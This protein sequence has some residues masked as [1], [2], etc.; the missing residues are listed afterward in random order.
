MRN[1]IEFLGVLATRSEVTKESL[2]NRFHKTTGID[3]DQI[4]SIDRIF[5][6]TVFTLKDGR[7]VTLKIKDKALLVQTDI[8][9]FLS[10]YL[11]QEQLEEDFTDFLEAQSVTKNNQKSYK[12]QFFIKRLLTINQ[13]RIN[14]FCTYYNL[15]IQT[16]ED[17]NAELAKLVDLF[18]TKNMISTLKIHY[19]K[20]IP[21]K[22]TEEIE[23]SNSEK[24]KAVM[25]ANGIYHTPVCPVCGVRTCKICD[26]EG[27]LDKL[28]TDP[29]IY[30][31]CNSPQCIKAYL[32]FL[33]RKV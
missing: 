3:I 22:G 16:L 8:L 25:K 26:V 7:K 13:N 2:L 4:K 23:G 28:F 30:P 29:V 17:Y 32:K 33:S 6:R 24:V 5:T 19:N 18:I 11:P 9:S 27:K 21:L 20:P 1:E 12:N 14:N 15:Q 10:G 31:I